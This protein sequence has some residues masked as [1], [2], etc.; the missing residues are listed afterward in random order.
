MIA[1]DPDASEEMVYE[2]GQD[3]ER[4][5]SVCDPEMRIRFREAPGARHV[6]PKLTLR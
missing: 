4:P 5:Q 6:R 1:A 3:G 2:Y